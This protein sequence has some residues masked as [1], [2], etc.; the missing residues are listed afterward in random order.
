MAELGISLGMSAL[1]S[2]PLLV[3]VLTWAWSYLVQEIGSSLV[4]FLIRET[5][6]LCIMGQIL[7]LMLWWGHNC[8]LLAAAEG[9]GTLGLARGRL[10][11]R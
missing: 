6:S 2:P 5:I 11:I 7:V 3:A 10:R 8:F 4:L 1:G 9:P